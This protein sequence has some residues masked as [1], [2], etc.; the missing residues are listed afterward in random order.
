MENI[1]NNFFYCYN[2]SEGYSISRGDVNPV[3]GSLNRGSG[4]TT[5]DGIT[6]GVTQFSFA[7]DTDNTY[8]VYLFDILNSGSLSQ[9][10]TTSSFFGQETIDLP[11]LSIG[12]YNI[13][14]EEINSSGVSSSASWAN[15]KLL[16]V[17][18]KTNKIDK[19]FFIMRLP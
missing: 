18:D 10:L 8:N 7:S 1:N 13:Q 12:S 9:S 3:A 16:N 2:E 19:Y 15:T 6:P 14:I 4:A 5:S 17:K 11:Q